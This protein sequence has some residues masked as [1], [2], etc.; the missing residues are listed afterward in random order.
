MSKKISCL[1]CSKVFPNYLKIIEICQQD[2][3]EQQLRIDRALKYSKGEVF[4]TN[5]NLKQHLFQQMTPNEKL[6]FFNHLSFYFVQ[7]YQL[8]QF[9]KTVNEIF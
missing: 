5:Q 4:V 1:K 8:L 2:Y 6:S 7:H 3:N 9:F